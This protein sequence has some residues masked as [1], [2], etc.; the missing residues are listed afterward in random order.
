MK[1]QYSHS[2]L[3]SFMLWVDFKVT[4]DESGFSN[5]NTLLYPQTDLSVPSPYKYIYASPYK[6]WVYDNCV[7]GAIVPSGAW[8]SSGQFLTR[9]SGISIDYPNGRVLSMYN[10]GANLSG[11]YS[12]KDFTYVL[13]SEQ[14]TNFFLE[15]VFNGDTNLS[16]TIT[17]NQPGVI[18]APAII[19]TNAQSENKPFIFG[20]IDESYYSLRAY[21][22]SNSN[23]LQEG[24]NS[25]FNDVARRYIPVAS[26]G[27]MPLNSLGDLKTAFTGSGWCYNNN[28][29]GQYGYSGGL[30]ID[31]TASYKMSEKSK[32]NMS[33]SVS[34]VDFV[35]RQ[36]R[37]TYTV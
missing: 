32:K 24:I 4:N 29:L 25:Y 15:K 19:F 9:S 2:L 10:W 23:Y 21:I 31:N 26:F 22:L 36:I 11:S 27:D 35:T 8:T 14:E 17:G 7:S 5:Y 20:G 1:P 18:Y 16:Y 28:I 30:W 6:S 13:S 34:I 37:F 12:V 33:Y 3:T